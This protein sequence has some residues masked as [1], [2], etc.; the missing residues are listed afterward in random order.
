MTEAAELSKGNL[1]RRKRDRIG[2]LR[3]A[4]LAMRNRVIGLRLWYLRRMKKMDLG[5][6]V[7]ISLRANLDMTNPRG[8]HIGSGTYVAFHAVVFSH[9]MSRLVHTDTYIG[10]NCFI[11]AHAIIMPGVRI[12]DECIV[13]SGAVVTKDIPSGCIVGG[14]PARLI[15]TGIR[16]RQ[17]GILEDIYQ[18]IIARE[19]EERRQAVQ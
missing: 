3:H 2:A 14:N 17:Y 18:E 1:Q 13:G 5:E 10:R 7:K 12:G 15:R 8:V 9:D 4:V 16:T 6:G 11:G 19:A